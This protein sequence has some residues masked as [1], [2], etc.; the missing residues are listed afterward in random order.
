ML[1]RQQPN[2][3]RDLEYSQHTENQRH[4]LQPVDIRSFDVSEETFTTIRKFDPLASHG[5]RG[6]HGTRRTS[7]ERC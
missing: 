6:G 5:S 1:L 7:H 2:G 4:E 3:V